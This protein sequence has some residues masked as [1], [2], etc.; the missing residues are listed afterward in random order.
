[1]TN[2]QLVYRWTSLID[3]FACFISLVLK[4]SGIVCVRTN[5]SWRRQFRAP[6]GGRPEAAPENESCPAPPL[7]SGWA[8]AAAGRMLVEVCNHTRF[9][10]LDMFLSNKIPLTLLFEPF[11]LTVKF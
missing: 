5:W 4:H 11:S 8:R 2:V 6:S 10:K 3:N 9:T 1:M 7:R